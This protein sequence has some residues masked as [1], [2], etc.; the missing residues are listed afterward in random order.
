MTVLLSLSE[1]IYG[2]EPELTRN[3]FAR[4]QERGPQFTELKPRV[5]RT[6]GLSDKNDP[7]RKPDS[8]R[9]SCLQNNRKVD[10]VF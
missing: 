5:P 7:G 10:D 3:A 9:H 2:A 4:M 8:R 6:V 1:I